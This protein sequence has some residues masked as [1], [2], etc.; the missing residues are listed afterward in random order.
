MLSYDQSPT[1]FYGS[2]RAAAM[3]STAI[4]V[5]K[6]FVSGIKPRHRHLFIVTGPAGSG[7]S[8]V[9]KYLA[10]TFKFPYIEGDEV[11]MTSGPLGMI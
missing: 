3:A 4:P 2:A 1:S 10:D 9:A 11:S 6:A 8:T 5:S 7:K